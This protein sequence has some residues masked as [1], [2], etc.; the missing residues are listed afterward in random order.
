MALLVPAAFADYV[1][2]AHLGDALANKA[3]LPTFIEARANAVRFLSSNC[4]ADAVYSLTLRGND[5][6]ELI[7][8]G[9]RGGAKTVWKVAA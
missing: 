4:C 6:V 5:D 3:L 8:F 9:S 7:R 1:D 2:A